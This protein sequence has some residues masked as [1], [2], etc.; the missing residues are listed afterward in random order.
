MI[1]Q[2]H[3]SRALESP[4]SIPGGLIKFFGS[5]LEFWGSNSF[6][7]KWTLGISDLDILSCNFL[8]GK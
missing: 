2:S 8:T 3:R 7:R 4:G 6:W 5:I 1:L